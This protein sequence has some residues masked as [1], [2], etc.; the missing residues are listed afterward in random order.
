MHPLDLEVD[1]YV[2]LDCSVEQ[3]KG[4]IFNDTISLRKDIQAGV[5][6]D[7][8]LLMAVK[9]G[10]LYRVNMDITVEGLR[11]GN[12]SS[13]HQKTANRMRREAWPAPLTNPPPPDR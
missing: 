9:S 12:L 13:K 11:F 5:Y 2:V 4:G 6:P 8:T 3:F 10:N 1:R 7:G